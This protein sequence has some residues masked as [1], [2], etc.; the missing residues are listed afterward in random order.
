MALASRFF[1]SDRDRDQFT[2]VSPKCSVFR[3]HQSL[4]VEVMFVRIAKLYVLYLVLG[5]WFA[6]CFFYEARMEIKFEKDG[7]TW[8]E[9]M[10][11][12]PD[13]GESLDNSVYW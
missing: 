5:H 6:C 2:E 7:Q 3:V 12:G 4:Q 11:W 8:F 13:Q 10:G 9:H 1:P